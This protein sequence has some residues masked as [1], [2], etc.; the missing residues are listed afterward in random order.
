MVPDVWVLVGL[1]AIPSFGEFGPSFVFK[2]MVGSFGIPPC[3][4]AGG[5]AIRE[6]VR[7]VFRPVA[8]RGGVGDR[9]TSIGK[10]V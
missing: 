5:T 2:Q 7:L 1:A 10:V 4:A 3:I 6:W 9:G 8:R